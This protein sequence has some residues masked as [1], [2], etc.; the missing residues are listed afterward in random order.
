MT[1]KEKAIQSFKDGKITLNQ[2]AFILDQYDQAIIEK[3]NAIYEDEFTGG[4]QDE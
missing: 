1:I 3:I 2:L 4:K